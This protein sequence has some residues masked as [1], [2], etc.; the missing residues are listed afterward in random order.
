MN[1]VV[2]EVE[3]GERPPVTKPHPDLLKFLGEDGIRK[4]VDEH[5]EAIR[6]S[7][8]RFMFPMEEEEFEA[9]KK[10]AADF[11]IQILGG[12]PHFSETRGAPRM[13]GR[14]APFRITPSARKVWLELYIPIFERL[15][16]KVPE[17]LIEIFWNYLNIFSIW[18][19][20]TKEDQ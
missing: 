18:M 14:H 9:A 5:Y 8:I 1:L 20:N 15:S 7:E 11:F 16:D 13:V 19:I 17:P 6:D 12:H 4:I 3:F 2:T 10:R